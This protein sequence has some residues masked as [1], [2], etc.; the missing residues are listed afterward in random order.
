MADFT[1][2]G[3]MKVKT[4]KAQF[5]ENFGATL[6]V[7][8]TVDCKE[9]ADDEATLASIRAEGFAGGEFAV[10][11]NTKVLTF[12]KKVAEL[13]GIGVQVANADDTEFADD[14]VTLAAEYGVKAIVQPGG[15]VRDEDSIK[16]SNECGITMLCTGMRHFKH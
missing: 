11:G 14:T 13:Y 12:E 7:Y 3:R 8:T 15:S 16:K 9:L 10:K 4:V 2:D 6:R 5:K 1:F